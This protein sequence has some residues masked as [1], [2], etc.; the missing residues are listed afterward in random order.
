MQTLWQDQG[1]FGRTAVCVV[2]ASILLLAITLAG[3]FIV[4]CVAAVPAEPSASHKAELDILYDVANILLPA[5]ALIALIIAWR[6]M[7]SSERARNSETYSQLFERI[8][9]TLGNTQSVNRILKA[10]YDEFATASGS[11]HPMPVDE[12][13]SNTV[14]A[15]LSTDPERIKLINVLAELENTGLLVR[16]GYIH[17]DDIFLLLEGPLKTLTTIYGRY[18]QEQMDASHGGMWAH[19][20]WLM[21]EVRTYK[22]RDYLPPTRGRLS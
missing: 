11:A 1:F 5:V 16:R 7:K 20:H 8:T 12:F 15:W 2:A 19:T 3:L 21:V 17:M 22:L 10:Q 9:Q 13:V 14:N 4:L 18:I 6:Q